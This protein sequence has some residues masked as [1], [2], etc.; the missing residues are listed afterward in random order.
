MAGHHA[1]W[2]IGRAW[3]LGE[4]PNISKVD[5]VFELA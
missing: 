5:L 3:V 2:E 4:D 1:K